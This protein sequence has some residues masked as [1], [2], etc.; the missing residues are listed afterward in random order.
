MSDKEL[1]DAMRE[2]IVFI[3]LVILMKLM[4]MKP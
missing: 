2:E 4:K 1:E 3:T